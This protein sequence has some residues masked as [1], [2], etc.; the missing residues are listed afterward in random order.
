MTD[1]AVVVTFDFHNTIARCDRWFALE[2]RELIPAF[3]AWYADRHGQETPTASQCEDGRLAYRALRGEI[4]RT[5]I[6]RD[7]VACLTAVLPTLGQMVSEEEIRLGVDAL[8]AET[9]DDDV[10][11]LPGVIDT[12]RFLADHGVRLGVI[13]SAVYT[14][15]LHWSLDR[16]GLIEAFSMVL[17]SAAAGFYKS[18]P[19]IYHLA[20]E[21]LGA[22]PS[23][24]VHVGDSFAFDVEGARR[25]GFRTVWVQGDRP[26]P[27]EPA[28]DL[29][30]VDLVD[31]GPELLGLAR[32]G[33]DDRAS[34][35]DQ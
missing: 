8:M 32:A 10:A 24:I 15:F 21:R 30:L 18:H 29:T 28:A 19:G 14:P 5:G 16:F 3:L 17:T 13:S 33:A 9:F 23:Q 31:A 34:R 25:A 27:D 12:V 11:P 1:Q 22:R 7:A 6:E 4:R 20:A 2:I 26:L 35:N